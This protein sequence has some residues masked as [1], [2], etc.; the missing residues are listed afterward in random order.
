MLSFLKAHD[1]IDA[2]LSQGLPAVRDYSVQSLA[3]LQRLLDVVPPKIDGCDVRNRLMRVQLEAH[4]LASKQTLKDIELIYK[5][6]IKSKVTRSIYEN[7]AANNNPLFF[8]DKTRDEEDSVAQ[9]SVDNDADEGLVPR[10]EEG[11]SHGALR[12]ATAST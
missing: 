9:I 11:A 5:D 1:S 8:S 7:G 3:I 6:L 10:P 12:R 4:Q 2:N